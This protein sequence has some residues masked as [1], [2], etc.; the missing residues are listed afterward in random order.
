MRAR[1]LRSSLISRI[2][3]DDDTQALSIWFR[4][5]GRYVYEGVPRAIYDALGHATSAGRFFNEH[6]KGRYACRPDPARRRH[7]PVG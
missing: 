5:R 4:D 1:T 6:I 3:W 7:R 2:L